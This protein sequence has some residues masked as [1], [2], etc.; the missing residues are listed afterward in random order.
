MA[1]Q[2]IFGCVN[3]S[4]GEV[5]FESCDS[6]DYTACVNL[7]TGQVEVTILDGSCDDTYNGCINFATGKF[8]LI[9][10]DDC[11]VPPFPCDCPSNICLTFSGVTVCPD[12]FTFPSDINT[13]FTLPLSGDSG[14]C[15]ND[16]ETIGGF[17]FE[18]GI[19]SCVLSLNVR[20]GTGEGICPPDGDYGHPFRIVNPTNPVYG[21][22][23]SNQWTIGSCGN[24]VGDWC[25]GGYGGTVTFSEGSC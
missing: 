4:T 10:P 14:G 18:L 1:N 9:I 11:C 6:E 7:T 15:G 24:G 16:F 17:I 2:T 20:W 8:Q 5:I 3:L 22:P 12:N 21:T 13:S 23:Y 19:N 25:V